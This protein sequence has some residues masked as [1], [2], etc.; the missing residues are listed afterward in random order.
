MRVHV[1][2]RQADLNPGLP[3]E[4]SVTVANDGTV[5]GG[6]TVRILGADPSWVQLETD[7]LSLFPQ[8]TRTV[9]AVVTAPAGIPAGTRRIAVQVREL[10]APHASTI[11]EVDLTVPA[12]A[13]VRMRVDPAAVTGG[14]VAAFSVLVENVG[15]TVADGYLDGDDE[16]RKVRF[17]FEPGQVVLAPGQHVMVEA[18]ATA[19]RR[20]FGSL[21]VRPISIHL[22]R[23]R[24]FLDDDGDTAGNGTGNGTGRGDLASARATFIQKSVFSRSF[25]SLVGLLAAITVFA[26]VITIALARLVGQSTADR[27]LA[28]QVAEARNSTAAGGTSGVSGAVTLLTSGKPVPGVSVSV[29]AAA[30]P[31]T[32]VATTGTDAQG[33][34]KVANLAAGQYKLSFRGAG[35]VQLWYPGTTTAADAATITLKPGQQQGGLNVRLGGVPASIAGTV[36]GDDISGATVFLETVP[37]GG[38]TPGITGSTLPSGLPPGVVIPPDNGGAVVRTVPIGS[39]GAFTIGDVPSPSIYELAVTKAGYATATVRVDLDAG[40][41][42]HGVL[43]TLSKGDGVISGT[44]TSTSGPLGGVTLTATSGQSSV[45]TVSATDGTVGSFTLRNLPTPATFTVTATMSGFATSTQT[46]SLAPGQK[47]PNVQITL[48]ASSGALNGVVT[49][50]PSGARAAGV[51]VTVTD[52]LLTVQTVTDATGAWRVAGLPLPGTYTI[53]FSRAD[54]QSQTVSVALDAGGHV[55]PGSLGAA[56]TPAGI[57]TALQSSTSVVSGIITQPGGATNC[58]G[59]T[60]LGEATVTL[61]SGSSTYTEVSASVPAALCGQYRFEHVPA[62]TYTITVSAGGGTTPASQVFTVVAGQPVTENIALT[63]P[64]VLAGTVRCCTSPATPNPGARNGWTVFL[65][66]Q[67]QYPNVVSATYTTVAP[68]GSFRFDVQAGNYVLATGPTNDP[69]NIVATKS[70]TVA[71]SQ[72]D[73]GEVI[74]VNQ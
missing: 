9:R 15:N 53:T 36:L 50:L 2:P 18:E 24:K 25:L 63:R 52:G 11:A 27:N 5:I 72:Q 21:A 65:Y 29:Y 28:L 31:N 3:T 22:R 43:I 32:A 8:D 38:L 55:T 16:E 56:I 1:T 59:S 35:F 39:D 49:T 26:I 17:A 46:Y 62:G 68:N 44:V 57:A 10:T 6:Y 13:E 67:S 58:P 20:L 12:A 51:N 23:R 73:T 45:T 66:T 64:A 4:L 14:R 70:V 47:I 60:K 61:N 7:Q 54:L 41:R 30:N 37:T 19:K 34:Y 40:E 71:P 74:L 69:A 48:S 33:A 42:R